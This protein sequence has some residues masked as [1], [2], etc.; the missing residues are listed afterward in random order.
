MP[1][2]K[3]NPGRPQKRRREEL[4]SKTPLTKT[5]DATTYTKEEKTKYYRTNN[6]Q[7]PDHWYKRLRNAGRMTDTHVYFTYLREIEYQIV[8]STAQRVSSL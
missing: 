3:W 7:L 4:E 8:Q 5:S 2:G 1:L 6:G